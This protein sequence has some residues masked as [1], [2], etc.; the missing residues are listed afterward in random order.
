MWVAGDEVFRCAMNIGEVA[1]SAAGDEDFLSWLF[2][3]LEY[4][5]T[6]SALAGFDST[7][8]SGSSCSQDQDVV[9]VQSHQLDRPHHKIQLICKIRIQSRMEPRAFVSLLQ[10]KVITGAD[11]WNLLQ[12]AH[13]G[14]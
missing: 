11:N 7:H 4:S 2:R 12:Y 10:F 13:A 8:Q 3:A 6:A 5:D 14:R 1:A 9:F